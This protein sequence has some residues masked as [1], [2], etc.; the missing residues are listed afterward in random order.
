MAAVAIL[1]TTYPDLAIE[2][3][4]LTGSGV[5]LLREDGSTADAIARVAHAEVIVVGSRARFDESTLARL[6]SRAIVRAGIGVETIDLEAA[7]RLGVT[8]CNVPDYGTETVA[9]HALALALAGTRR[10]VEAD[11]MVRRGEWGFRSTR[12]MHL[13]S[14]M[15]AGVLGLGRIGRRT[16]ELFAAIGFATVIGHDPYV[17]DGPVTMVSAD[18]LWSTCD[19]L[20]LH[21]P[22]RPDGTPLIGA[23][24]LGLMRPG[25][26]LVNT[27]RGSLVDSNALARALASGRPRI[28]ALDVFGQEPPT[29]EEFEGV[30]DRLILSP[31]QAWYSEQS[32]TDLRRKSAQEALRIINGEA[33]LNPVTGPATAQPEST[34]RFPPS[35][36]S[37]REAS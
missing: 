12:P 13:P 18:E 32:Q 11:Q 26:V 20:S 31:H 14:A 3:A 10:L 2:E 7:G 5:D 16:A 30:A 29:L 36:A 4:V 19:V 17:E 22:G 34:T 24:Q 9:Q 15:V 23:A 35:S 28:A 37:S 8:V 27:A 21:V 33:P 6:S 1:D 25:S